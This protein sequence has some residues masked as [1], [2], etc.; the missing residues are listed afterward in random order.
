M[1]HHVTRRVTWFLDLVGRSGEER[2]EARA[3]HRP[4]SPVVGKARRTDGWLRLDEMCMRC[5]GG[6][7]SAVD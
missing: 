1:T 7:R 2:N 5:C 6:T 4:Y 3:L